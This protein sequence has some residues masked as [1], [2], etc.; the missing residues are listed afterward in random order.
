[1]AT[2]KPIDWDKTVV[3][4][5]VDM[6]AKCAR[7]AEDI[8]HE[9]KSLRSDVTEAWSDSLIEGKVQAVMGTL[10]QD[11]DTFHDTLKNMRKHG[12]DDVCSGMDDATGYVLSITEGLKTHYGNLDELPYSVSD[13]PALTDAKNSLERAVGHAKDEIAKLNDVLKSDKEP[14]HISS[15]PPPDGYH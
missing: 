1:M 2:L 3:E 7:D 10:A 5:C 11:Y 14:I 12:E 15:A 9:L 8:I 6:L 4:S 13:D